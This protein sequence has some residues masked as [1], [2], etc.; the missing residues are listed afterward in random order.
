MI[1]EAALLSGHFPVYDY[2]CV[3]QVEV[4]HLVVVPLKGQLRMAVVLSH[5]LES[6][7]PNHKLRPI[8][9]ILIRIPEELSSLLLWTSRYYQSPMGQV[10]STALPSTRHWQKFDKL[11][12]LSQCY[13]LT[14]EVK[15]H[16]LS[17]AQKRLV[18]EIQHVKCISLSV[19][20][21]QGYRQKTI[22]TLVQ[23]ECLQKRSSESMAYQSTEGKKLNSQQSQVVDAVKSQAGYAT[24]LLYGVTG[25]G[26]TEVYFFL[27]DWMLS[28]GKQALL[29]VPE[30]GLTPQMLSRLQARFSTSRILVLH[31]KLTD[32]E[33]MRVWKTIYQDEVDILVGTRSAIFCPLLRLGIIIVDEEHDTS[34]RQQSN[35][36]YSARDLAV[37]RA[38]KAKL[39]LVLGSAT[40]SLE[41][42]HNAHQLRYHYHE[43]T[44]RHG[45]FQQPNIHV[46][47]VRGHRLVHGIDPRVLQRMR[48]FVDQKKPVLVFVN[49]RG[50]APVLLC[51]DCGWS[52]RCDACDCYMVWHHGANRLQCHH[53]TKSIPLPKHCHACDN[54][55]LQP[56]GYGTER[57]EIALKE[58]FP[59][60]SIQRVDRDTQVDMQELADRMLANQ[61]DIVIG[62]QMLAKGHHF[63][64]LS[65]AVVVDMDSAIYASDFRAIETAMQTL[66]QVSGRVGRGDTQGEVIVQTHRPDHSLFQGVLA[67]DYQHYAKQMLQ[68][69]Q[70]VGLPPYSYLALLRAE[71]RCAKAAARFLNQ[72]KSHVKSFWK[73][74]IWGPVEAV[75]AKKNHIYRQQILFRSQDRL[76]LQ[77]LASNL[78]NLSKGDT[79]PSVIWYLEMDPQEVC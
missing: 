56:V 58:L 47:D 66:V 79:N 7:V 38:K 70:Q 36:R 76:M 44:L 6:M 48:H 33:R 14:K 59:Q 57:L 41:T 46:I 26:K 54:K 13:V 50:Y 51:H 32:L 64:A 2:T 30:I 18:E 20:L 65:L 69:R 67:Q 71:S 10:V 24:H 75:V 9:E 12:I 16:R 3:D 63:P 34:Y 27:I 61:V 31:S 29:L 73:G 25:S 5:K 40:P 49:R 53:C 77:K 78:S 28:Q 8:K 15:S 1:I 52:S 42:L 43:L 62:T 39:P 72:V 21:A 60:Q 68:S 17:S 23:K 11:D 4:G 74:D 35:L 37:V 22:D 55:D 45:R 19:L